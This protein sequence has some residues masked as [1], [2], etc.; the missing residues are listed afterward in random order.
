MQENLNTQWRN[1][2][3]ATPMAQLVKSS[4]IVNDA[5][6]VLANIKTFNNRSNNRRSKKKVGPET[7]LPLK[8]YDFSTL[9]TMINLV[10]LKARLQQLIRQLFTIETKKHRKPSYMKVCATKCSWTTSAAAPTS[11]SVTIDADTMCEWV[12]FLID[13]TYVTIG[14]NIFHQTTGIPMGT[15]CAVFVANFYL[16]TYERDFMQGKI[17]EQDFTTI[18]D[19]INSARYIDDVLSVN[20]LHFDNIKNDIYPQHMLTLNTEQKGRSVTFLDL[21]LRSVGSKYPKLITTLFDKRSN[22][23][24]AALP[25]QRYPHNESFIPTRFKYNLVNSQAHRFKKRCLSKKAFTF[26]MAKLLRECLLLHYSKRRLLDMCYRFLSN[27]IPLYGSCDTHNLYRAIVARLD[28]LN[29]QQF[30]DRSDPH[31]P[32]AVVIPAVAP[33]P[34]AAPAAPLVA[35]AVAAASL[36]AAAPASQDSMATI[37][38]FSVASSVFFGPPA[39]APSSFVV[40][41]NDEM[42]SPASSR[43]ASPTLQDA[44]I[45]LTLVHTPPLSPVQDLDDWTSMSDDDA[46]L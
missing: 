36:F 35:A 39:A 15:N 4:W 7:N 20:S 32:P 28:L 25:L 17:L 2:F 5:T 45:D 3:A 1:L 14:D 43:A 24:F 11:S 31:A 41:P 19:I 9:Y 8:T 13:N 34:T 37:S 30:S 12:C 27:N 33:V 23:K 16:Y 46:W 29:R 44:V 6:E 40:G 10:D 38:Q 18:R 21:R 42:W 22:P 26:N